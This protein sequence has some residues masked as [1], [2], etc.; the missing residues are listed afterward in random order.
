MTAPPEGERPAY[1]DH[2]L[3]NRAIALTRDAYSLADVIRAR[4]VTTAMTLRRAAVSIPAHVAGAL[5]ATGR[6]REE[7]ALA[8]RGALAEVARQA[9]R[10]DSDQARR[11]ESAAADLDARVLFDFT[12]EAGTFS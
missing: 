1:K 7:Q 12:S 3:W 8:A 6:R 5:T 10:D 2:P 9:R 11:L 4:D